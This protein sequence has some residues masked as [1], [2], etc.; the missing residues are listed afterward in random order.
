M[1]ISILAISNFGGQAG[2]ETNR[3][4]SQIDFSMHNSNLM[5]IFGV[6]FK[7]AGSIG[8]GAILTTKT[9]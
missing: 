8:L 4:A 7:V 5:V 6:R 3:R 9:S 2:P 1:D